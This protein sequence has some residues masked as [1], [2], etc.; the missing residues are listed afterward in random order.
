MTCYLPRT[1]NPAAGR[2]CL[3]LAC[4]IFEGGLDALAMTTKSNNR[5]VGLASAQKHCLSVG[6]SVL[7]MRKL[8]RLLTTLVIWH[9]FQ[10]QQSYKI[11]RLWMLSYTVRLRLEGWWSWKIEKRLKTLVI[12]SAFVFVCCLCSDLVFEKMLARLAAKVGTKTLQ[13]AV[14]MLWLDWNGSHAHF[15][16]SR[17]FRT[18]DCKGG[19]VYYC[20]ILPLA[21][22]VH[23]DFY[24]NGTWH[25]HACTNYIYCSSLF[26]AHVFPMVWKLKAFMS[27]SVL[28]VYIHLILW[29]FLG[30]E[31]I[32]TASSSKQ[33]VSMSF[34]ERVISVCLNHRIYC[35]RHAKF[36]N[37]RT[38]FEE[39]WRTTD[40]NSPK[41]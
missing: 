17:D 37:I 28:K 22:T 38:T 33:C 30:S 15:Y 20:H 27:P 4:A 3:Q 26:I 8:F 29:Y 34:A 18:I 2:S 10:D 24:S 41:S 19:I 16:L 11:H 39:L 35:K 5:D 7:K 32:D 23:S 13:K 31:V 6:V 1:S 9:R 12:W 40:Q 21:T 14:L 36:H 25:A